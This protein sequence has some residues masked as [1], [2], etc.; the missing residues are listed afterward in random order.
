[1]VFQRTA[2][3]CCLLLSSSRH[4]LF[5]QR[6]R[7]PTHQVLVAHDASDSC[8]PATVLMMLGDTA[9]VGR[10]SAEARAETP[11]V[12]YVLLVGHAF[13]DFQ[14]THVVVFLRVASTPSAL[15]FKHRQ[16]PAH[17]SEG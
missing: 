9:E 11:Q 8:L 16:E 4:A 2:G 15:G 1:M 10:A 13:H 6:E 14:L 17:A 5:P 7:R 12:G 3:L